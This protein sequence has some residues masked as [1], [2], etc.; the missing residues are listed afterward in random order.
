[1]LVGS[2][3]TTASSVAK[4]VAVIGRDK[5]LAARVAADVEDEARLAGWCREALRRW[6]HNPI[7]LRQAVA[8]TRLRR[9]RDQGERPDLR[10]DPGGD[11][12]SVRLPGS[13]GAPAGSARRRLSA[14]R[15]RAPSLRRP[16]R[17]RVPNPA[18]RRSAREARDQ[19]G[20][21]CRNGPGPSPLTSRSNS[22]GDPH[23]P[24]SV[25]FIAP[26][27]P[28]RIGDAE[29]AIDLLG[30]PAR[31]DIKAALDRSSRHPARPPKPRSR[32]TNSSERIL[33]ACTPSARA[34]A[35]APTSFSSSPPTARL[36]RRCGECSTRSA[37]TS[38]RS[39][40]WRRIGGTAPTS[41]PI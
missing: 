25:T 35:S 13:A 39:S 5:E 18:A 32:P 2:I 40:C 22:S 4:I 34:T 9:L 8:P 27:R 10:L 15:R 30:N 23:E 12:R 3:D 26:L 16:G 1:M 7:V 28:D 37:S 24:C 41:L 17:Q 19:V 14:F 38:G 20:R 6:P 21:L 33:R 36:K 31:Q 11:A 29:A